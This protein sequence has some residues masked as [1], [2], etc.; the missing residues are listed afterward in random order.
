MDEL[1][2]DNELL[3]LLKDLE[4]F[5]PVEFEVYEDYRHESFNVSAYF[6]NAED[7]KNCAVVPSGGSYCAP[8]TATGWHTA[9]VVK[10]DR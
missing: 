3:E 5:S 6:D 9:E 4:R 10:I 1:K 8:S 2:T 7:C